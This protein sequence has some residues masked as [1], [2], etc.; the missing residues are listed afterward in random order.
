[1][2]NNN[3]ASSSN[4]ASNERR[5]QHWRKEAERASNP[6]KGQNQAEKEQDNACRT[7][8]TKSSK[9]Q[10]CRNQLAGGSKAFSKW[11]YTLASSNNGDKRAPRE[12][13]SMK[14]AAVSVSKGAQTNFSYLDA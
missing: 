5:G 9:H 11:G 12:K 6:G 10:T 8:P 1:M 4:K 13:H 14:K 3:S 7:Y 2:G